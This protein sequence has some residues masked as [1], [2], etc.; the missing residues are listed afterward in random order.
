VEAAVQQAEAMP[1]SGECHPDFAALGQAFRANFAE[2]GETGAAVCLFRNG[3]KV[4]NLW[5]G[6][7]DA[8]RT[9]PWREDTIVCMMSVGKGMAALCVW[10][11][12]DRGRIDPEAPVAHYWPEFAGGG[13]GGIDVAT[14]LSGKAGLLYADHA[15]DG[16]AFDWETMIRAYERQE[17]AWEPGT[18]HG[19]HSFSGGYLLGELVRRVDG[20]P[21]DRFLEEEV[22]A[23]LGVDYGYGTRGAPDARVAD[24]LPNEASHTFVQTRNP[25]TKLGRAWRPR[26]E[27]E[28]HYNNILYRTGLMPSSNGHGNARSVARIFAALACGGTIDGVRLVGPE[29]V[30]RMREEAWYGP[31]EMTDRVFRYGYGFFLNEPGMSPMGPNPGSFGHP[32]A[33]GAFGFADPENRI[34]FGYSPAK[35]CEGGGLGARCAALVEAA[36]S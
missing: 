5:G 13:K 32:G 29:T 35:M 26:P 4:V 11:L 25:G 33:G 17:P 16:A 8:A 21:I 9:R 15:P 23:P 3:E 20:R 34:S 24:V 22:S 14:L 6:W 1:I 36:Y 19:Y 10:M 31:C 28:D 30:N 12:I 2:R 27:A 7:A 18:G